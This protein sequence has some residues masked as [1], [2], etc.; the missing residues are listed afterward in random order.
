MYFDYFIQQSS[1][2][3]NA[4]ALLNISSP[5]LTSLKHVAPPPLLDWLLSKLISLKHVYSELVVTP[6]LL[7][8]FVL[9]HS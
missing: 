5:K 1:V 9:V 3:L 4:I 6:I 2:S 7:W 8:S